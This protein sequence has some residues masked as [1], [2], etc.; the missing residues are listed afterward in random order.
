[1]SQRMRNVL[2]SP[3][4]I[5]EEDFYK[6]GEPFSIADV[7]ARY[8]TTKKEVEDLF[9]KLMAMGKL[10]QVKNITCAPGP[11]YTDKYVKRDITRELLR[12]AWR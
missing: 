11:G 10:K 8:G 3:E 4:R 6:S 5:T 9:D 7:R 12:R 2:P 1:M